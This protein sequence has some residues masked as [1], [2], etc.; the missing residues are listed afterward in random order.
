MRKLDPSL[1]NPD[2]DALDEYHRALLPPFSVDQYG[3]FGNWA[4]QIGAEEPNQTQD[5][6]EK[7][8]TL[9]YKGVVSPHLLEH[10]NGT[11]WIS[12]IK[13]SK[14]TTAV[15]LLE[16][17]A[18]EACAAAQ[19]QGGIT[20]GLDGVPKTD[21]FAFCPTKETERVVSL[22]SL[23]PEVVE[24]FIQ[25]NLAALSAPDNYLGLW[26]DDGTVYIDVSQVLPDEQRALAIAAANQQLAIFDLRN[27]REIRVPEVAMQPQVMSAAQPEVWDFA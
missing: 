4:N 1:M 22:A 14:R 23:T 13:G 6:L 8:G 19:S 2:E 25:Q 18:N 9:A 16:V 5:S 20:I 21:G 3:S 11:A 15:A 7:H 24:Q 27:H 10:W 12:L 17:V 26:V